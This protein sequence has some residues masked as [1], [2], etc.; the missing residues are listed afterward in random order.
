MELDNVGVACLV[1]S[2]IGGRVLVVSE[3]ECG[4][5]WVYW[6]KVLLFEGCIRI[7]FIDK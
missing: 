7:L 1:E 2:W 3:E 6:V 4:G 5:S